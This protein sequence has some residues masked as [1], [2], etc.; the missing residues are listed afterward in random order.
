VIV[1]MIATMIVT[2]TGVMIDVSRTTTTAKTATAR[3]GH[4][5]H[6]PKG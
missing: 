3:S 2:T 6:R 5:R 1:V 4:L